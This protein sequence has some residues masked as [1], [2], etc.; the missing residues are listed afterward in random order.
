MILRGAL[1]LVGAAL[2][3]RLHWI[4]YVF[5]AF[6]IF[7]GARM[8]L[9]KAVE[10]RPED[11]FL[12]KLLRRVMP[13]TDEYE[14]DRFF[15]RRAG[16]LFATPLLLVLLIVESTDVVF[17]VDS[18]P[19]IFAVTQDPFIVYTSNVF[20]ILGLRSLYFVLAGAVGKFHYLKLAL[21]AILV[22]VGIKMVVAEVYKIPIGVS[23]S[24]IGAILTA[25]LFASWMRAWRQQAHGRK[26]A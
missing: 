7:T 14:R 24:V 18:I 15:V 22:F 8:A 13:V 6:L 3:E 19:A 23:L 25:A 21:S 17:A 5:G 1:I 16:R 26:A 11:N 4:I 10:V 9:Q 12:V 20:A 2:L